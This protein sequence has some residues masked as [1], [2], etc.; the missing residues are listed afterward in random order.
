MS[1][2]RQGYVELQ[3]YDGAAETFTPAATP[4]YRITDTRSYVI[5]VTDEGEARVTDD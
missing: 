3:G 4:E 2:R 5:R 1:T